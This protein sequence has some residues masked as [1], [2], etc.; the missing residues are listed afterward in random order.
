MQKY[1]LARAIVVA[2]GAGAGLVT[3]PSAADEQANG[4][5]SMNSMSGVTEEIVVKASPLQKSPAE[6]AQ[7]SLV[8]SEQAL[9][10]QREATLGATLANQ[11]G[12]S[13][14]SFGAAVSRPVIRGLGGSRVQ[15]LEDG[16]AAV[17]ASTISPDHAVAVHMHGAQQVEV[18][19][20]PAALLYGSG[21]LGGV[22]NVVGEVAHDPSQ[23]SETRLNVDYSTVNHGKTVGLEHHQY[24]ESLDWHI[25]ASQMSADEYRVPSDGGEVHQEE[26]GSLEYHRAEAATLD[27]S[28]IDH[29]RELGL[30]GQYRFDNGHVGVS[31][32]YLDSAFGLPGHSHDDEDAE[33]ADTAAEEEGDARVDLEQW[34]LHLEG[35]W[36]SPIAA[37]KSISTHLAYTD[38][39]HSEGHTGGHDHD[40]ADTGAAEE[41]PEHGMTTF[42]RKVTDVR[43]ELTLE[44]LAGWQQ[45]VGGQ[46]SSQDF[47]ALGDEALVPETATQTLAL[48]WMGERMLGDWSVELGS[49]LDYTRI[50]PEGGLAL[51]EDDTSSVC[52]MTATDYQ[53]QEFPDVSLS[54][55]L[56][57]DF[58]L[59]NSEGW[60]FASSLTSARRAPA[61]EELYSCGAHDSTL[62]Y[63]IG[64]PE[65]T[66]EQALNVDLGIGKGD[67]DWQGSLSVY[68]NRINH[69]IYSDAQTDAAGW[70]LV[71]DL[72]AYRFEQAD[73]VLQGAEL[74]VFWQLQ[75]SLRWSWLADRVRGEF[76]AGGYLPR[77]PADRLGTGLDWQQDAIN[78]DGWNGF[79]LLTRNFRQDR[80][81]QYETE[82]SGLSETPT[83]A[84]TLLNAGVGY[85][86]QLTDW[87]W[88]VDLKGSNLL[89][90]TVRYHTSY[91]KDKFP[92]PGRGASLGLTVSF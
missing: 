24:S 85:A 90:E 70:L 4:M 88:Q 27:N 37:V 12:I 74:Q 30:G 32:G 22:V 17:D 57:R 3:V 59:G 29:S 89:D 58:M 71:D 55:G 16:M 92:Q 6:L 11:P 66:S 45:V 10:R 5:N 26:D 42:K 34:R 77:M 8:L 36:E 61:A 23:D 43:I 78:G 86:A 68:R 82:S 53:R 39:Q 28:D 18:L 33:E 9:Q 40:E 84:F 14:S 81:A 75:E 41:T 73:A 87:R 65:L 76:R 54:L 2:C 21:A 20:G 35:Y 72:Q 63:E 50:D 69:Y 60:Q 46:G 19:R 47:S 62:A 44:E 56:I 83:A 64:N 48:F 52:G 67:G 38:Y 15:I 25:D 51:Q 80:L 31:V 1:H 91:V 7:S 79:V 49:R 13:A